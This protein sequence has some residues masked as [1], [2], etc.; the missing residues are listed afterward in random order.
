MKIRY[1][2]FALFLLAAQSVFAQKFTAAASSTQVGTGEQFQVDFTVNASGD[3]FSPPNFNGFQVLSGP[4]ISQ[5][6]SSINGVTSESTSYSYILMAVKEGTLTI[7]PA[8]IVVNGRHLTTNSLSIRV[9]K[10]RPVPKASR[11]TQQADEDQVVADNS[12]DLSKSIFLR[13]VADKSNVYQ[14]EQLTLTFRLYTRIGVVGVDDAK[15][16]ELNGFWSEEV[17]LPQNQLPKVETYKGVKYNVI[18]IKQSILF[19]ERSGDI[20]ID[21]LQM[22]FEVQKPVHT[23][24]IFDQFFGGSVKQV[25]LALKTNQVIIH[26]KPLPE[27]GKPAG[28]NG[29]VGNFTVSSSLDK[30]ELKS[31]ESLNYKIT[32]TGTG[33]LK[34]VEAPPINFPNDFEKYDPKVTDS[35]QNDLAVLKGRREFNYLLI[36]RHQGNY[37]IEAAKFSYFNPVSRRYVTLSTSAYNVKV[38]KGATESNVTAYSGDED[39]RNKDIRYIKPETE[40]SKKGENFYGSVLYYLLLLAGPVMFAGAYVYYRWN[41]SVNSDKI[42]VKSRNAGRMAT[43]HLSSAKKQLE[44]N[45]TKMFYEDI[46]RGLYGY[47]SDKF[48]I[49]YADLNKENIAETLR[50]RKVNEGQ[51]DQLMD[52]LNLC[53]MARYAPVTGISA[54]EVFSKATNIINDIENRS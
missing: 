20:K 33:N 48:N 31:N 37:T 16:P 8:S 40:F 2:I 52:T 18:D 15:I 9:V 22:T 4:N 46:S 3:R 14:G 53:E 39:L 17:K 29:A 38:N 47:I 7:G 10:G 23:N 5:S 13:A 21:P 45:N 12:G 19:P 32:V 28:F 24:D 49:P 43:K 51:I 30:K 27:A 26:V 44:A 42:A 34:L 50:A 25:K 54:Q 36:P 41:R 1:Y 6:M 11:A 35:I